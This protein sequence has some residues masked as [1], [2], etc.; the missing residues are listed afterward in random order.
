MQR[1][2][3]L[4]EEALKTEATKKSYHYQLSQ[5][6]KWTKIKDFDSLLQAPD[7][8]IQILLEDYAMHL[9]RK[10]SPNSV[11]IYFA[12]IELFFVMNDKML[13]YKKIRK[14]FPGKAKKGNSRGYTRKEIQKML[15]NTK[16]IRNRAIVLLMASS[17][18]RIGAIPEIKIKHMKKID[19]ASYA[20]KIYEGD[21]EEDYVFTTPE[22]SNAI[23]EY[24]EQRKKQGEYIDQE[25]PLI[26]TSDQLAI[27]KARPCNIDTLAHIMAIVVKSVN[28]V[29][30]G[31]RYDVPKNH[32]YRKYMATIIKNTPKIS[33]TM[34][35]KLVNHVGVVQTDGSYFKPTIEKMFESYKLAIPELTISD[36][37]RDALKIQ[38]YEQKV[39][40]VEYLKESNEKKD[41][42]IEAM[43]NEFENLKKKG[44]I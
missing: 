33:V 25:S 4:F 3:L 27:N 11:P 44:I 17:G 23:D 2:I 6:L 15:D 32:G 21:L 22:A 40:D 43:M 29:K 28:K 38:M 42:Q 35:E 37:L 24:L 34:S 41:I 26:R 19:K 30:N 12:P 5:F 18:L 13:N 20:I 14:L 10:V 16:S 9:K 1:S 7:K 31:N 39:N 36:K 8:S